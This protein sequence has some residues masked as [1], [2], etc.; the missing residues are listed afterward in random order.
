MGFGVG[1]F[2]GCIHWDYPLLVALLERWD[3]TTS[4]FHLL[5]GDDSYYG[6]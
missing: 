3:S 1:P 6:G 4:S 5:G 2:M